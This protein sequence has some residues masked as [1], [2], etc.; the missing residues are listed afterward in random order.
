MPRIKDIP[1]PYHI[2]FVS[3]D[4]AE[5]AHVHVVRERMEAKFW[6]EPIALVHNYGFNR[7]ELNKIEQLIGEH[8]EHIL[9]TWHEH[10]HEG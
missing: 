5:P 8:H 2:F 9:E 3:F 10:C 6:L 1:G 4:C 7:R